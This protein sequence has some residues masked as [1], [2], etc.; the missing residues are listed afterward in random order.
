MMPPPSRNNKRSPE[1]PPTN[2]DVAWKWWRKEEGE[3]GKNWKKWEEEC[4]DP[5]WDKNY[6]WREQDPLEGPDHEGKE[7]TEDDTWPPN[8]GHDEGTED[9]T[10][11]DRKPLPD[12]KPASESG[13]DVSKGPEWLESFDEY[14]SWGGW[15]MSGLV[16]KKHV[17]F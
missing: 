17:C 3:W 15:M 7:G 10:W 13:G 4:G 14:P 6:G 16:D 12:A 8:D 1:S 9:E 5:G 11:G 2:D